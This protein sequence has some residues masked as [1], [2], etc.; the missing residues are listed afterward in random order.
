[1]KIDQSF[2]RDLLTD[3]NDAVIVCSIIGLAKSLGFR[4]IAEGVETIEQRDYLAKNGC[5]EYQGYYFSK[6]L[7][8]DAFNAYHL[9]SLTIPISKVTLIHPNIKSA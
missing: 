8:I 5:Q 7:P 2:V 6:P 1:L 9:S 3:P 4:V